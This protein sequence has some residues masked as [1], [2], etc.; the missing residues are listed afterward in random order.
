MHETFNQNFIFWFTLKLP[1]VMQTST[2]IIKKNSHLNFESPSELKNS[3][4]KVSLILYLKKT[5]I[6][7]GNNLE[8]KLT[9]PTPT[10]VESISRHCRQFQL[11]FF[12]HQAII[13]ITVFI[14]RQSP[15]YG[16]VR[17]SMYT[18]ITL[19]QLEN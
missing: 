6:Y 16:A 18:K 2:F 5:L 17:V 11:T 10:Y 4:T 9:S 8:E 19:D 13:L 1:E 3:K 7:R 12:L 14:S 15:L